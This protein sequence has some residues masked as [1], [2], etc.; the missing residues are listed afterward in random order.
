M[1]RAAVEQWVTRTE[2]D[3]AGVLALPTVGVIEEWFEDIIAISPG[4]EDHRAHTAKL[5]L[6][7]RLSMMGPTTRK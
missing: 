5:L 4:H 7:E 2:T 6:W 1:Q 3:E